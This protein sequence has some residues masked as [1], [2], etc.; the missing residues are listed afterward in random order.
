MK[1]LT[2]SAARSDLYNLVHTSIRA[3]TPVRITSKTGNAI[4][5]SESEYDSLL[6]TA[7]RLAVPGLVQSIKKADKEL[8]RGEFVTLDE[9]KQKIHKA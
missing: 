6:E 7:E 9:L 4:L 5:L 3:Q 2:T 1:T 8:S